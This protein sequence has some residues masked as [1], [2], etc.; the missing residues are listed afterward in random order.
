MGRS[1]SKISRTMTR[2]ANPIPP[3]DS[4]FFQHRRLV[5]LSTRLPTGGDRQLQAA[6][7]LGCAIRPHRGWSLRIVDQRVRPLCRGLAVRQGAA[8]PARSVL[9]AADAAFRGR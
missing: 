2:A 4:R 9:E 6:Q 7:R 8:K 1:S 5:V 3:G